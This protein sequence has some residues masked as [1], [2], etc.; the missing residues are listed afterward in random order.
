MVQTLA[1]IYS[2]IATIF[3]FNHAFTH[4]YDGTAIYEFVYL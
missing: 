3:I 2:S 1:F 4:K